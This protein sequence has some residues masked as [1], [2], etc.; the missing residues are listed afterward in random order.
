MLTSADPPSSP[1]T[2]RAAAEAYVEMICFKHGPPTLVGVELEWTVHHRHD[3]AQPIDVTLL[4]SALG[5]HAPRTVAPDS[6]HLPLPNG[7]R[8]TVEP[9][10]QVELSTPPYTSLSALRH[11]VDTDLERLDALLGAAGLVRGEHATDA[12]RSPTRLLDMPRYGAMQAAFD[13]VGAEGSVMMCSTASTQ[14]CLDAGE[15]TDLASRW[16][17]LHSVGP[18]MVALFANA[19]RLAGRDTGW[20]SRRL[21][22]TLGTCPPTTSPPVHAADPAAAWAQLAM[23]AP[24]LCLRR[25]GDCWDAPDGLTFG[26]WADGEHET[27]PTSGDLDYHL[28][29]LFPPVR[30]RGYLEVRYLDA[31]PSGSWHHPVLLLS[32]LMSSPATV[33][34]A[35]DATEGVA[36]RWLEAARHGLDDEPVLEAASAIVELGCAAMTALDVD[37]ATVQETNEALERRIADHSMRRHSA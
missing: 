34:A 15:P 32:A 18:A 33:E 17:A 1:V 3:A 26:A 37:A 24:V 5:E 13:R 4:A 22:S 36:D 2:S 14:V 11:A 25:D 21:R 12:H 31:Q 23:S 19:S 16:R 30:P 28:S 29:T 6:P 9:G 8:I 20:A 27:R 35:I 10:G 7:S